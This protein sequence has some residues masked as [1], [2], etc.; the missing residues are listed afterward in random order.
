VVRGSLDPPGLKLIG[1]IQALARSLDEPLLRG[2]EEKVNKLR[3]YI[4][5]MLSRQ[6]VDARRAIRSPQPRVMTAAS[7]IPNLTYLATIE[8]DGKIHFYGNDTVQFGVRGR[9][10]ATSRALSSS[11]NL[12]EAN[13]PT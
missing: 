11:R 8:S 12:S 4:L 7:S 13:S 6:L 9:P 2:V 10:R 3:R 5:K 1:G